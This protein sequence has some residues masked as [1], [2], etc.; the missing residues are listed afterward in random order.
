MVP[1][2]LERF[3]GESYAPYR[4]RV[5]WGSVLPE[6]RSRLVEDEVRLVQ[7]GVHSR[8]RAVN[9]LGVEGPGGGVSRSDD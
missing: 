1:R 4:A 7:A 2:L 9:E 5:I 6:D 8:R 3:T